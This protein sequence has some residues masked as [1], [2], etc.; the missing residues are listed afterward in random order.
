[1]RT[2]G[3]TSPRARVEGSTIGLRVRV[4]AGARS[5]DGRDL[6][7]SEWRGR[8]LPF[9]GLE[10]HARGASSPLETGSG[11]AGWINGVTHRTGEPSSTRSGVARRPQAYGER[12][13]RAKR[14]GASSPA[15]S[16]SLLARTH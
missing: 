9:K 2:W 3:A 1:V 15:V 14:P 13:T 7:G 16:E 8:S 12:P 5:P 10:Y 6:T 4:R 11:A